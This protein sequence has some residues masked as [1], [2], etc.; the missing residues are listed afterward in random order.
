MPSEG[1][2]GRRPHVL[3]AWRRLSPGTESKLLTFQNLEK[4][5]GCELNHQPLACC[6]SCLWWPSNYN[7]SNSKCLLY[8]GHLKKNLIGFKR[9]QNKEFALHWP[10]TP[11]HEAFP[12]VWLTQ[13]VTFLCRELIFSL[14]ADSDHFIKGGTLWPLPLSELVTPSGLNLCRDLFFFFF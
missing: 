9:L 5:N 12:S 8:N 7:L 3:Q 6:S 4:I 14:P 1:T 10:A 2:I 13:P 11:G